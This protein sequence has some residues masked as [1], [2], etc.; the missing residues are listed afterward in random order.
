MPD[1]KISDFEVFDA[2]PDS[3]T[4][5]VASI[6]EPTSSDATNVRFP[7]PLLTETIF[8]DA[9]GGYRTVSGNSLHAYFGAIDPEDSRDVIFQARGGEKVLTLDN[10]ESIMFSS[11]LCDKNITSSGEFHSE[12]GYFGPSF[13]GTSGIFSKI[14]VGI[15]SAGVVDSSPNILQLRSLNPTISFENLARNDSDFNIYNS[16]S[17][18]GYGFQRQG[19]TPDL[20]ISFDGEIGFGTTS[21]DSQFHI[22][23]GDET[24]TC[25][26][27]KFQEISPGI[28]GLTVKDNPVITGLDEVYAEITLASGTS[29]AR[30]VH[31]QHQVSDFSDRLHETGQSLLRERP[32][33]NAVDGNISND[34]IVG[35]SLQVNGED[36][37]TTS[38]AP[39]IANNINP[40][41]VKVNL[42]QD[43]GGLQIDSDGLLTIQE[44]NGN[45]YFWTSDVRLKE[46]VRRVDDA[47]STVNG[48]KGVSFKWKDNGYNS[49]SN[50]EDLGLIAQD[51]EKVLPIAVNEQIDGMM[52]IHYHRLF[53]VLIEAIKE[54]SS[55]V[56]KLEGE[57][58][59]LK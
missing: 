6:N 33:I 1:K 57:L 38:D 27:G 26:Y 52:G 47:L 17:H 53:P 31:L 23:G 20:H 37:L 40:G 32:V 22:V 56:S 16:E 13:I 58:N 44:L 41:L 39:G 43:G 14:G 4:A 9:A 25:S 28:P 12:S 10:E 34:L 29:L 36:V 15:T 51:L 49:L 50:T 59:K 48:M 30:D 7:F 42:P 8:E 54:L 55:K 24:L 21:P 18:M 5:F 45:A 19:H 2:R 46:N 3:N 35:N 11:F